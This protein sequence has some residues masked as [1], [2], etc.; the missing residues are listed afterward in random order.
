[1]DQIRGALPPDFLTCTHIFAPVNDNDELSVG[2]GGGKHWSLL[3]ISVQDKLALHYDPLKDYNTGPARETMRNLGT[4]LGTRL[5]FHIM[6]DTPTIPHNTYDCGP[7]VCMWMKV[8]IDRL[9]STKI[10][11]TVDFHLDDEDCHL[12]IKQERKR[13]LDFI[14]DLRKIEPIK[15]SQME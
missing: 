14:K 7:L 12:K 3:M 2:G 13:I 4:V 8:L 11:D 15:S 10:E 9:L 6:D 1:M 5:I